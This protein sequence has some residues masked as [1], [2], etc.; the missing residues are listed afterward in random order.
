MI[1]NNLREL[2]IT[3]KRMRNVNEKKNYKKVKIREHD[4]KKIGKKN[5]FYFAFLFITKEIKNAILLPIFL[6]VFSFS[7]LTK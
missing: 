4:R 6:S 1:K 3:L 5:C 2:P 7:F